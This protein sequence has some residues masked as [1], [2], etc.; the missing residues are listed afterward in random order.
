MK[1]G[2]LASPSWAGQSK[3]EVGSKDELELSWVQCGYRAC[4]HRS[5]GA[6]VLLGLG[7]GSVGSWHFLEA[8]PMPK[9]RES[10]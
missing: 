5:P 3:R 6:P 4:P 7:G 8:W 1:F 10:V 9:E 2:S